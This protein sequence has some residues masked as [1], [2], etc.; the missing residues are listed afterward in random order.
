VSREIGARTDLTA[1]TK[2]LNMAGILYIDNSDSHAQ[3]LD[4]S[5]KSTVVITVIIL[6]K[7]GERDVGRCLTGVLRQKTTRPIEVIVIDSGST[8]KTLDIVRRFPVRLHTIDPSQF[9]H[10]ETRNLAARLSHGDFLVYISQDAEPVDEF[11]LQNLIRPFAD[12]QRIAGVC[13]RIL[14]RPNSNPIVRRAVLS[15]LTGSAERKINFIGSRTEYDRMSPYEKRVLVSFHD[16]SS[17]IKRTIWEAIPYSKIQFGEDIDWAK[18]VLEAGHKTLYEPTSMVYHSHNYL[19]WT[20]F[21]RAFV[22]ATANK[23]I[24]DRE[25]VKRLRDALV[26][27]ARLVRDDVRYLRKCGIGVLRSLA[28]SVYSLLYH[29]AEMVG[30]W[31]GTNY[32]AFMRRKLL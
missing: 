12:D 14:P 21:D 24:L 4:I 13:S 25:N 10:G 11:W 22:D 29:L 17:C 7:N 31:C 28:Y 15:D 8:D 3:S 18:R 19:P 23:L 2:R 27:T 5:R 9:N 30:T 20:I 1:P 6:T 26:I 16:I 32:N